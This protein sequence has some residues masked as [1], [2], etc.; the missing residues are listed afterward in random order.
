MAAQPPLPKRKSAF[1]TFVVLT[2]A[3]V[4]GLGWLVTYY[5]FAAHVP[6]LD[7][8]GAW[9]F[10]IGLGLLLTGVALT[11]AVRLGGGAQPAAGSVYNPQTNSLAIVALVLGFVLPLAAI[12]VGHISR[13]QIRRSGEQGDGLALTGLVLGY[14]GLVVAVLGVV[15][16]VAV[17]NR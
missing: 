15:L 1:G 11:M 16:V 12:P 8:M 6:V 3:L 13:A 9:N 14:L 17:V 7:D 4:P 10:A 2:L 5:L